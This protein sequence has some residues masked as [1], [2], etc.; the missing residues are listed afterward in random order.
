MSVCPGPLTNLA[1]GMT[2]P[3]VQRWPSRRVS[4]DP[5]SGLLLHQ[6]AEEWIVFSYLAVQRRA[7]Q[8]SQQDAMMQDASIAGAD[9]QR[10]AVQVGNC[11][12]P[13]MQWLVA[14]AEAIEE[15][16]RGEWLVIRGR[17]LVAHSRDF[18]EIQRAIAEERIG[19]PFVYY[20]PT[21]EEA[22]FIAL[23]H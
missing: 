16:H 4:L 9:A 10:L 2:G 15:R 19:S 14:N 21:L 11:E 5:Q 22:N 12:S 23:V 3:V 17:E 7:Q 20:V 18:A 6:K 8:A 13:E 1:N